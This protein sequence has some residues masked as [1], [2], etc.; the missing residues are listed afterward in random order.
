MTD[1]DDFRCGDA[2][3]PMWCPLCGRLV[4]LG[5]FHHCVV[6]VTNLPPGEPK[7]PTEEAE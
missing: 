3:R 2:Y 5:S 7:D 4:P 6:R 1:D